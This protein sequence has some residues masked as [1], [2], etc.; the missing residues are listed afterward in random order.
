[1]RTLLAKSGPLPEDDH[2]IVA[3]IH[4]LKKFHAALSKQ[5]NA[6]VGLTSDELF[7]LRDFISRE[8]NPAVEQLTRYVHVR[9]L[10]VPF[11]ISQY[12]HC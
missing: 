12:S 10:D 4:T 2:D 5:N 6:S 9:K 3:C 11:I 8:L 1:M 7:R